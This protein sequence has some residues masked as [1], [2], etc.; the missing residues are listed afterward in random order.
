MN[1]DDL[2]T[3]ILKIGVFFLIALASDDSDLPSIN[4]SIF[5]SPGGRKFLNFINPFVRYVAKHHMKVISICNI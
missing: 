3:V 4:A 1:L 5:L 2:K